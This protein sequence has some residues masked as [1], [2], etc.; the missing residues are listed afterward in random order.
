[1]VTIRTATVDD[2]DAILALWHAGAT[3]A[4]ST[5]DHA[6]IA[7]LLGHAP[8]S[9]LLAL[10]GNEVVGTVVVG[11]D[12]WRATMY[13]LVVG[14]TRRR[15]G[16]ATALVGEAEQRLRDRGARRLHLIVEPDEVPALAFWQSM[17]YAPTPQCRMVKT[18][19]T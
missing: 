4:S 10:D 6:G 13:R 19:P 7:T 9:L 1:M 8:D 16:I 5:D 12:G 11:W 3:V 15:D 14:A 2:T 18:F 17:G